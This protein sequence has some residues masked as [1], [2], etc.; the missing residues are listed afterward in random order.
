MDSRGLS[1]AFCTDG[2]NPFSKESVQ[3][4]TWPITLAV[5][6]LPHHIRYQ[7]ASM[8]I[9]GI[10]PGRAEPHNIDPYL[11]ILIDELEKNEWYYH[12]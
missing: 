4:S 7:A 2:V 8:L 9:V 11:D 10:I 6:N 12:F 1:F 5:L 3:Y